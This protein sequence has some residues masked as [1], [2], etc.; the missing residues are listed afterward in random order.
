MTF[1]TFSSLR[2]FFRIQ[3]RA[4]DRAPFFTALKLILHLQ[5]EHIAVTLIVGLQPV[6]HH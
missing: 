3:K 6:L 5:A 2:G 4:P 1:L